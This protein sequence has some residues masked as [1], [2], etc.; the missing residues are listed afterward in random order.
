MSAVF[1]HFPSV[2]S[3]FMVGPVSLFFRYVT[4]ALVLAWLCAQ[5]STC[6]A[7]T[8]VKHPAQA[9]WRIVALEYMLDPTQS[10]SIESV[11][12]GLAGVFQPVKDNL[13][14]NDTWISRTWLRIR[15]QANPVAPSSNTDLVHV[16]PSLDERML[17]LS[18]DKPFLDDIRLYTPQAS[19]QQDSKQ[20]NVQ[21]GGDQLA[22]KDWH[23]VLEGS[24]PHFILP[25]ASEMEDYA[26]KTKQSTM[27]LYMRID[28]MVPLQARLHWGSLKAAQA[29]E[30]TLFVLYG[31]TFG[32]MLF[33]VLSTGVIGWLQRDVLYGLYS[34]YALMALFAAL[35]HSGLAHKY[36]W[37]VAGL[38]PGVAV[39]FF[40]M[41]AISC[42]NYF[43]AVMLMR[44]RP[45]L[46]AMNMA[47]VL[48]VLGLLLAAVFMTSSKQWELRY[49]LFIAY[50]VLIAAFCSACAWRVAQQGQVLG[51]VWLLAFVPLV[52][53][54]LLAILEAIGWVQEVPYAHTLAIF[55]SAIE[56]IALG[57]AL[58]WLARVHHGASVQARTL[59]ST[60][61]LTGFL[62]P[63]VFTE[64]LV[65]SWDESKKTGRELAV[66]YVRVLRSPAGAKPNDAMLQRSVRIVRAATRSQ[67]IVGRLDG[68]HLAILMP[69]IGLS[70]ELTQRLSRIVALGLMPDTS[71]P[72][73]MQ[74]YFL[75]VA[76]T[77]Q[78]FSA[79]L[80]Q[81]DAA[82]REE[83]NEQ[84]SRHSKRAIHL[85]D[86]RAHS[87]QSQQTDDA[88][89]DLWE[90]ALQSEKDNA[91]QQEAKA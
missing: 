36:L 9:P 5:S 27:T 87:K 3:V 21:M 48:A 76:T 2:S 79:R 12:M 60:D 35:S 64:H 86:R 38:W 37:P 63:G 39:M 56:V 42:L 84:M 57:F 67:D 32:A 7:D 47:H 49:N 30:S 13:L 55:A 33:V 28:G 4:N 17:V 78:A 75:I 71:D 6:W 29:R 18:L 73:A 15:L 53:T 91:A 1:F 83:L 62:S 45:N 85:I 24:L 22:R 74:L 25:T 52:T 70:D 40:L 46:F 80:R 77:R 14:I 20:W 54:V 11:S 26:N 89:D 65:A 19:E 72:Q 58:Q 81:L 69:G 51:K 34:G 41:L 82:L 44:V 66:V 68:N 88:L 50:V 8:A 43:C 90:K 10:T 61:P 31:L 59:A 23:S 16:G